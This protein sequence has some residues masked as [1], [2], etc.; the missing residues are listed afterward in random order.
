[1][2]VCTD[3]TDDTCL[4]VPRTKGR[5]HALVDGRPLE[6]SLP[7]VSR[8]NRDLY[9]DWTQIPKAFS[10]AAAKGM[11]FGPP[12][13]PIE[14]LSAFYPLPGLS[15]LCPPQYLFKPLTLATLSHPSPA[16]VN[17]QP[18][19]CAQVGLPQCTK[20]CSKL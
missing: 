5:L 13:K 18:C 9:P 8:Q 14:W 17:S 10:K 3:L 15:L 12:S 2:E 19:V 16:R 11:S 6:S 1:M 20:R 7:R 4:F